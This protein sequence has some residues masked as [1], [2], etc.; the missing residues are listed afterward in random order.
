MSHYHTIL[1]FHNI[2]QKVVIIPT[3]TWS[4][5]NFMFLIIINKWFQAD[6]PRSSTLN[7]NLYLISGY[8]LRDLFYCRLERLLRGGK[9]NEAEELC[10]CFN[11]PM[12]ELN[13]CKVQKM[14]NDLSIWKDNRL[15]EAQ[16]WNS[17]E[18]IIS[19]LNSIDVSYLL[20]F[21]LIHTVFLLLSTNNLFLM[22][23]I[24]QNTKISCTNGYQKTSSALYR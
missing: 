19:I 11:W 24:E 1:I 2:E 10:R 5:V 7:F 8:M 21:Y 23:S 3:W 4:H 12:E 15:E 9:F 17:F 22:V 13:K 14:G 20:Y 16:L 18:E 6:I